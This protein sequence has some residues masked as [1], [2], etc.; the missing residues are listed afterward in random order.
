MSESSAGQAIGAFFNFVFR[1]PFFD[2]FCVMLVYL[3][4]TNQIDMSWLWIACVYF[5]Y[6]LLMVVLAIVV[7][8]MDHKAKQIETLQGTFERLAE[9]SARLSAQYNKDHK[10]N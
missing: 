4:I 10:V 6:T 3:K 7:V 2:I 1:Q 5:G 9:Q 8:T